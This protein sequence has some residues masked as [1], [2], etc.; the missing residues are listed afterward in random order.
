MSKK[1]AQAVGFRLLPA[2]FWNSPTKTSRSVVPK[3]LNFVMNSESKSISTSIL[4]SFNFLFTLK[5]TYSD[6]VNGK[7]LFIFDVNRHI[8]GK[9]TLQW[10]VTATLFV[11]TVCIRCVCCVYLSLV[12]DHKTCYLCTTCTVTNVNEHLTLTSFKGRDI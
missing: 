10:N 12:P 4:I 2:S 1:K 8:Y 9:L 5:K 6:I 7:S 11:C 3:L